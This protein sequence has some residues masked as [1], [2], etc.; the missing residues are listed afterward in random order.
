[1]KYVISASGG[2]GS[3]VSAMIAHENGLD[4]ECV[5]ADTKIEDEDLY[6]FLGDVNDA[7][8]CKFV[9][10]QDGRTPWQVFRDVRFIGNQQKA[11][12]SHF[13]KRV[14]VRGYMRRTYAPDEAVLV[15][16]MGTS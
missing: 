10:L 14:P 6:R 9:H 7:L 8:K 13:L 2:L 16:G 12:C 3:A 1:M 11:Q 4:Y 5:F 15:L